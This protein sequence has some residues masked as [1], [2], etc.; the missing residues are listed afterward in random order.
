M[1]FH[2][3]LCNVIKHD[4]PEFLYFS[5]YRGYVFWVFVFF[6]FKGSILNPTD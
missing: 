1:T 2:P 4:H 6:F 5:L 3:K